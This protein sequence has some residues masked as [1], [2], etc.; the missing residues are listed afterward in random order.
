MLKAEFASLSD[1]GKV[2]EK[3]EDSTLCEE[4]LFGVADGMGGHSAGEVA[5]SLAL[6]KVKDY[7]DARHEVEDGMELVGNAIAEANRAIHEKAESNADLLGM[8]TT[9][10]I[11][12]P[13]KKRAFLGH[14]GDSRAYLFEA[15]KLQRLTSDHSLVAKLLEDGEITEEEAKSH[16]RRNIILKALGISPEVEPDVF[17][18]PIHDGD[19]FL[20]ATDG[21]TSSL[22]DGAIESILAREQKLP[23]LARSLVDSA[24]EVGGSDNISVVAV[25]FSACPP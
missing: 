21:L 19:T 23:S 24:L 12:Y 22:D 14:V 18:V 16:P 13:K 5:S 3:N 8:G 4:Y 15:G 20:L 17:E 10:T 11:L 6:L 25:R 2:R 9:I 7:V 1:K